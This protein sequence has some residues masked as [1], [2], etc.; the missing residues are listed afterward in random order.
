MRRPR[1]PGSRG[2]VPAVLAAVLIAGC[3]HDGPAARG[4]EPLAAADVG[5]PG[6]GFRDNRPPVLA[7]GTECHA[8]TPALRAAVHLSPGVEPG[9][10][11]P[12]HGCWAEA[13]GGNIVSV[14]TTATRFGEFWRRAWPDDDGNGLTATIVD[15]DAAQMFERFLVDDR[16]YAIRAGSQWTAGLDSGLTKTACMV[17]ADTGAAEPLLVNVTQQVPKVSGTA[18]TVVRQCDLGTAVVRTIVG[19]HDPGGGSRVR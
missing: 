10:M 3:G 19:E 17:V 4:G 16:Y 18:E 9:P 1:S 12:G 13:D 11:E 2:A 6:I 14:L 7:P 15:K 8:F 5:N